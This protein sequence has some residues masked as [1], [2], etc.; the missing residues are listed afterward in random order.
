VGSDTGTVLRV[1]LW[2]L[3]L[4]DRP[5]S[6]IWSASCVPAIWPT[7]AIARESLQLK[8]LRD[9]GPFNLGLVRHASDDVIE[10][11]IRDRRPGPLHQE[12]HTT[13]RVRDANDANGLQS[14]YEQPCSLDESEH[15]PSI[16]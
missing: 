8:A 3:S 13:V 11:V 2:Y 16:H 15:G 5:P 4:S 1:G 14:A 10:L 6:A 7:A 9:N 12:A